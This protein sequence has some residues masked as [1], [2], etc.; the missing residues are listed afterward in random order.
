M[1]ANVD[2]PATA[3]VLGGRGMRPCRHGGGRAVCHREQDGFAGL[4]RSKISLVV[5][6]RPDD[7]EY[8]SGV[9]IGS[10]TPGVWGGGRR[11]VRVR[12]QPRMRTGSLLAPTPRRI[13]HDTRLGY[14][15]APQC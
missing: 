4:L 1:A 3:R 13:G 5:G 7:A 6:T 14:M 2:R 8:S 10:P 15:P 11:K 12:L 9:G